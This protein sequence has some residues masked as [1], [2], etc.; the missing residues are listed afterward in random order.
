MIAISVRWMITVAKW[1][2]SQ[3]IKHFLNYLKILAQLLLVKNVI[4]KVDPNVYHRI[5]IY[6]FPISDV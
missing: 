1:L 2:L 6:N 3:P 5:L 4:L